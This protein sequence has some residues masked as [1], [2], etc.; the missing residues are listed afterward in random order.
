MAKA[1]AATTAQRK[2]WDRVAQLG[3]LVHGGG[4]CSNPPCIHHAETGGGGTKDHDKVLPLCHYHHQGDEGIHTMSRR[5]WQPIYG[6]ERELL[7]RVK[8]LLGEI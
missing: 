4:R 3:C 2:R 1:K 6:Y 5:L 8:E 7:E